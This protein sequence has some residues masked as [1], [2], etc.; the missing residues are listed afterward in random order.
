MKKIT[1]K[2][3]HAIWRAEFLQLYCNNNM[4]VWSGSAW[5]LEMIGNFCLEPCSTSNDV[6]SKFPVFVR[7]YWK[8]PRLLLYGRS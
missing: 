2:S 4:L 5:Q 7:F 3:F 8:T 1:P 6:E